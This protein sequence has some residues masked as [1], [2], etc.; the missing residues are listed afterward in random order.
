METS[1][2]EIVEAFQKACFVNFCVNMS[3]RR[4]F[5]GIRLHGIGNVIALS[6]F[7]SLVGLGSNEH[8]YDNSF[9][10]SQVIKKPVM[11]WHDDQDN[12]VHDFR[13]TVLYPSGS[14]VEDT[15]GV[16]HIVSDAI[17]AWNG[18]TIR[19]MAKA[20]RQDG[21]TC[22]LPV[23]ADAL[24]DAGCQDQDLINHCRKAQHQPNCPALAAILGKSPS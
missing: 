15:C 14:L 19:S 18:G 17:L 8:L 12:G 2:Q 4:R 21:D 6:R 20:I 5:Y 16:F 24:E 10:L 1:D 3:G 13:F 22:N 11:V 9:E 7:L 23:L